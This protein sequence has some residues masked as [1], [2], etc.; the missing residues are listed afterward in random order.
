ME[1]DFRIKIVLPEVK[2]E[3]VEVSPELEPIIIK[4]I[5]KE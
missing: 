3:K 4:K 2:F 1:R 5:V